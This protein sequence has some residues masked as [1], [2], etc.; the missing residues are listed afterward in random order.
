MRIC[1]TENAMQT[2]NPILI[3][4]GQNKICQRG[5]SFLE[6]NL[7]VTGNLG[8]WFQFFATARKKPSLIRRIACLA[9]RI[10]FAALFKNRVLRLF[11]EC[12]KVCANTVSNAKR[13]F[14]CRVAKPALDEAQ[15]GFRDA[16]LLRDDVIGEF[17]ALAL[18]S[19]EPDNFVA[20]GFV[21]ADTRHAEAWQENRFDI[22]FAI[23]K[24]RRRLESGLWSEN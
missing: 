17:P 11:D 10:R 1:S 21:M 12:R 23:V 15:H 22:Y 24:K 4:D 9:G 19:Q 16:R 6:R 8:R 14:Q 3:A 18:L 20:D 13:Q 2:G 7:F 5:N